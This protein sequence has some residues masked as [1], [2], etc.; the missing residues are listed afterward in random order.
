[1]EMQELPLMTVSYQLKPTEKQVPFVNMEGRTQY[2]FHALDPP[3]EASVDW[4]MKRF[5]SE[6]FGK[7][8]PYDKLQGV[9]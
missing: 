2:T 9:P 4:K 7:K 8:L 3:G 1:M 6:V 5:I